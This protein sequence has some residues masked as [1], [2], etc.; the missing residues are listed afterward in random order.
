M[1]GK[2]SD[3]S[4]LHYIF[5]RRTLRHSGYPTRTLL[6]GIA[7]SSLP[8]SAVVCFTDG[9]TLRNPRPRGAGAVIYING[10]DSYP[11]PL[12]KAISKRSTSYH[13]ELT[14][15]YLPLDCLTKTNIPGHVTQLVIISDC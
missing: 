2:F 3:H 8:T 6:N 5:F 12:H 15:I 9:S 11:V 4:L 13:G 7:L 14:A 10:L 1:T